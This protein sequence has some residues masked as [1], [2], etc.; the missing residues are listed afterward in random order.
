M[1]EGSLFLH[2]ILT[3]SP[4][5]PPS[6]L[7]YVLQEDDVREGVPLLCQHSL[8]VPRS[9]GDAVHVV[10]AGAQALPQGIARTGTAAESRG[11]DARG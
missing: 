11:A 4:L 3:S 6:H 9:H 8:Q 2:P 10:Q 1:Q 7:Q 5:L